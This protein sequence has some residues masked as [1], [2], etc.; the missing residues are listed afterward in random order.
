MNNNIKKR[1]DSL[2]RIVLPKQI[3]DELKI[4]DYDEFD[5]FIQGESILLKKSIGLVKFKEKFDRLLK[6]L[7]KAY[8]VDFMILNESKVISS[9]NSNIVF[10]NV[11]NNINFDSSYKN[12]FIDL[13]FNNNIIISSF[14]VLEGLIVDSNLLGY[15]IIF[16]KDNISALLNE[17]TDIKKL[18]ID[19]I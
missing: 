8:N 2:G 5:I 1:I 7:K 4:N 15:L 3:R 10:G 11:V 18:I 16:S 14:I 17:I 13:N 6:I 9:T 19:L 12:E